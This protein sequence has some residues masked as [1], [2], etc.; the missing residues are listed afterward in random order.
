M[1]FLQESWAAITLSTAGNVGSII[2]A[3]FTLAAFVAQI[4]KRR[5]YLLLLRGPEL[6]E[7]LTNAGQRL[8][9]YDTL[10]SQEKKTVLSKT[11]THIAYSASHLSWGEWL[12]LWPIR[13]SIL[14]HR[15]VVKSEKAEDYYATVQRVIV[16][17]NNRIR[18]QEVKQ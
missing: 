5:K 15:K 10:S 14:F 4:R 1:T 13:I 18:D 2:G 9:G 17:L 8:N 3:L 16:A 6:R 7:N 12:T 11:R